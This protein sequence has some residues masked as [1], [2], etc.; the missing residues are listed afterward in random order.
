MTSSSST[1]SSSSPSSVSLSRLGG[2]TGPGPGGGPQP[3]TSPP[4]RLTTAATINIKQ[5]PLHQQ[6][7]QQTATMVP[8]VSAP[9][10]G[11]S[12]EPAAY[13]DSTTFPPLEPQEAEY[14]LEEIGNGEHNEKTTLL[15][16]FTIYF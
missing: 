4:D 7:Q 8:A 15:V 9:H 5:E 3:P 6:Q 16:V 11:S 12:M 14:S 13:V 2:G 10:T 1:T